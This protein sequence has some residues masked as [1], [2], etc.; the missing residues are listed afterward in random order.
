[1]NTE[2]AP[3]DTM[4]RPTLLGLGEGCYGWDVTGRRVPSASPGWWV[5][6][7]QQGATGNTGNPSVAAEHRL[8]QQTSWAS[9]HGGCRRGSQYRRSRV[10]PVEGRNPGFGALTKQ[11]GKAAIDDESSNARIDPGAATEAIP[12]GQARAGLRLAGLQ[13]SRRVAGGMSVSPLY[14]TSRSCASVRDACDHAQA[15]RMNLIREPDAGKPHVRFDERA[16]ETGYGSASEAPA[17]ERA[18]NR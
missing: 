17:D 16:V 6:A 3:K 5:T 13:G 11:Q 1:M 8:G 15:L 7:C 9:G 2:T 14:K 4:R 10:M 18:G 12:E